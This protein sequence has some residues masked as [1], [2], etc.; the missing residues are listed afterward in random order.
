ML[1]RRLWLVAIAI[2]IVA[3]F[4]P[5]WVLHPVRVERFR[6][7]TLTLMAIWAVLTL[8]TGVISTILS[9]MFP[10]NVRYTGSSLAFSLAGILGASLAPYIAT[11]LAT[12]YGLQFVGYYLT[13]VA[14]LSFVGLLMIRET[15]DDDLAGG[16]M[17]TTKGP[18]A[19]ILRR[20]ARRLWQAKV[21]PDRW[22]R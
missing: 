8:Y 3:T 2:L 22:H 13:A 4:L 17:A 14:A 18:P 9:E 5:F 1:T 21:G 6:W 16:N 7:L 19:S 10:T 12:H 15:K 11:W 20:R